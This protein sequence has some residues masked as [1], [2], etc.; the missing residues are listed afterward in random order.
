DNAINSREL[1]LLFHRSHYFNFFQFDPLETKERGHLDNLIL[2]Y[3]IFSIRAEF[4]N[5]G[6][7]FAAAHGLRKI[8]TE[9]ASTLFREVRTKFTNGHFLFLRLRG[10]LSISSQIDTLQLILD[11][12]PGAGQSP[13]NQ[14]QDN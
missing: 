13:G 5:P 9:P 10:S 3:E 7:E 2:I 6:P 14:Q 11:I 8:Q 1:T 4:F 12:L